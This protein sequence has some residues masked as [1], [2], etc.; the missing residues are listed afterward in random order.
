LLLR[1]LADIHKTHFDLMFEQAMQGEK[2]RPV[3]CE[4]DVEEYL[5][6]VSP[7][8]ARRERPSLIKL[9][10]SVDMPYSIVATIESLLAPR[11]MGA[12]MDL[13]RHL[14]GTGPHGVALVQDPRGPQRISESAGD[15]ERDRRQGA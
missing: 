13:L 10:G 1:R 8:A 11:A 15:C 4:P 3:R 9:H 14:L 7:G 2:N 6:E 12:R 5:R